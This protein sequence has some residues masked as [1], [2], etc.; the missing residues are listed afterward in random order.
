M[1]RFADKLDFGI[2]TAKVVANANRVAQRMDRDWIVRGRRPAGICAAS[3][4]IAARMNGY[5]RTIREIVL[6]VKICEGTLRTRLKEFQQT[7]SGQLSKATFEAINLDESANPP[8]FVQHHKRKEQ[9]SISA[10]LPIEEI[11]EQPEIE[12]EELINEAQTLVS[13]DNDFHP[14]APTKEDTLSDLDDDPEVINSL[15]MSDDE[16]AFK[17]ELWMAENQDWVKKRE[18]DAAS[19][20]NK[21]AEHRKVLKF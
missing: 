12:E 3:L 17:K 18:A 15:A 8:S 9:T 5:K 19:G 1:A 16:T 21:K 14:N 6:V 10:V 4:Y 2:D 11:E 20:K 7:D 13:K